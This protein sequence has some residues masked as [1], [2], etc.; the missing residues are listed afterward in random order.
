MVKVMSNAQRK[1]IAASYAAKNKRVTG[2]GAYKTTTRKVVRRKRATPIY[3]TVRG[4]GG[5]SFAQAGKDIGSSIGGALG[6]GLG[7]IFSSG[8]YKQR[9]A[10]TANSIMGG[11]YD[12]PE[13]HNRSDR[14][15][16][17]RHR[18]F[19]GNINSSTDFTI[20]TFPI[21]PGLKTSFPWLSQVAEAFEEYRFT[22]IVYE[23]KT[24]CSDFSTTTAGSLGTVIM[25]SQYNA[26]SPPFTDKISM[27][28]YEFSND[29][30]PSLSFY[31]PIECKKSLNPVSELFVRTG[32]PTI[33]DLRLYDHANFNIAVEG[34][35]NDSGVI[36][37]LWATLECELY[38]P[39]FIAGVGSELLTDQWTGT[40]G[41]SNTNPIGTA[42]TLVDGSNLGTSI[43]LDNINAVQFPPLLS[44]GTFLIIYSIYGASTAV[45]GP[46]FSTSNC[47]V[48]NRWHSPVTS[49]INNS[50]TTTS[51]YIQSFVIQINDQNAR[52]TFGTGTLPT[53]PSSFDLWITQINGDIL[54]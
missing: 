2:R 4:R 40:V 42:P 36:G 26:L 46:A 10:V 9:Y 32:T 38:K 7:S 44:D 23:Y 6:Y 3:R 16:C 29:A 25:S 52:F 15:V 39:K 33:G 27:N 19:I 43:A 54:D 47:L 34:G 49:N 11:V 30:K 48:V 20:Q 37:E 8:D 18:E 22:G 50:G 5:Y 13:L 53:T 12:P 31:H 1:A 17:V 35:Q 21:N 24:M 51:V 28:N 41:I 45:T 14:T